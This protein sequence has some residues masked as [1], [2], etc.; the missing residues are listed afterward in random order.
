MGWRGGGD[1]P[2]TILG[3]GPAGLAVA[4]YAHRAGV[5]FALYERGADL[6]GLCRTFRFGAHS[7]DAGA[8][9]FHD[10]DP[11]VTRDVRRLLGPELRPVTAPSQILHRDRFIDFPPSPLGWLFSQGPVEAVR[12][13]SELIAGRLRPRPERTFEDHALNRYGRRL[14]KPL[15]LD[16]S[17]KLWG[18]PAAALDPGVDT[19]RL[20]GLSVGALLEEL[21]RPRR[22]AA[23]L[24]GEFL[25]PRT[26]YGAVCE[27]MTASLPAGRL[28]TGHEV[29][30]LACRGGRIHAVQVAGRPPVAVAGRLVSTLPLTLLVRLLGDTLPAA[31]RHAAAQ[32]RFRHV[33]IVFLRLAGARCSSNAS[34]YLPDPRLCVSRVS[35][36]KNRSAAMAPADETSLVAEVPCSSGDAI[37][38]L[39]DAALAERV[40]TELTSVGLIARRD[41]LAWRHHHLPNAYP[42]CSLDYA[43]AVQTIRDAVGGIDNLDLLGRNGRFWY[44]HLHDQLRLAKDYVRSVARGFPARQAAAEHVATHR[45]VG[46]EAV[47][48]TSAP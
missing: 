2:L 5:P 10:R 45:E 40:V 48:G 17:E 9:R 8:H 6:G 7:Y 11:D 37:S 32:L 22:K 15:L 27:R 4:Y 14:G 25:Y 36:P 28:H 19:R 39:D 3:G 38:G 44:S 35:E 21:L 30:G 23:H 16:Y 43:D 34:V 31:A 41:V 26:G 20:S 12:V 13:A 24:D 1:E 29:T 18:L 47:V 46:E 33:R 42:V